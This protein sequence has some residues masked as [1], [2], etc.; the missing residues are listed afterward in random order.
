MP[1]LEEAVAQSDE[2]QPG[3]MKAVSVGETAVLLARLSD[4]SLH[5]IG[6]HCTHYGAPL[7]DGA[8][9]EDRV[10]CPWHHA[11][12]SL[13]TGRQ[14]E[15]P[16]RDDL[17][18]FEVREVDGTIHV[19][20]PDPAPDRLTRPMARRDESDGRVFVV[21][22]G[23]AAGTYAV[24]GLREAGFTGR[25]V[26]LSADAD[27]PY[28]RPN[29]SKEYLQGEAPD[30][31]MPLRAD[32][33][34]STHDVEIHTGRAVGRLDAETKRITF[35]DGE[36]L[37]YD[38]CLVCTGGVPRTLD[39]PG[40]D[41][42]GVHT[43]RSLRDSAALRDAAREAERVVVVGASF[44]GMESAWS[45]DHLDCEVTV[46]GPGSEPF[47]RLWGERVGRMIRTVHEENGIRFRMGRK[48]ARIE[49]DGRAERVV[50]DDGST[51]EADLVLAGVGVQPATDFLTGVDPADDGGLRTDASL[52]VAGARDLWAAGD[53]A[54]IPLRH[55][56][57]RARIEHWRVACQHGRLAGHVMAG[58]DEVYA[59]VPFFWSGQWGVNLRYVGHADGSDDILY[60]GDVE[61]RDF[62]A[63]FVRDD[64]ILA[65]LGVGRDRAMAALHHLF[66]A[67]ALPTPQQVRDGFD[68]VSGLA[69]RA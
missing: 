27:L 22:G 69:E 35:D 17:P 5:A 9:H 26:L 52:R 32:D 44:I 67:D 4:G 10:V 21:L 53:V 48:V 33:F 49:G 64:R 2:L 36:T 8:L 68:P 62:L 11:C 3:R 30:E 60:D 6:G 59:E 56:L 19:R 50:L 16:G 41:L 57:G 66:V 13:R 34:W 54:E 45:L 20:V 42:D 38:A 51:I 31:W 58:R 15:P 25:I 23:G 29:C 39:V 46:V 24:M 28:D 61:A 18:R 63:Y 1:Y 12:F 47:V 40:A 55:G 7:A 65:A 37:D 14:L 43:L